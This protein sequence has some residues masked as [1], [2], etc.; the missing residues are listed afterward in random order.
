M[1]VTFFW[2]RKNTDTDARWF[3]NEICVQFFASAET[4]V[5]YIYFFPPKD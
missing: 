1:S 2:A 3:T 4:L 5:A